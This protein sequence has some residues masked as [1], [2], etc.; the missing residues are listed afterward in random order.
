M[1]YQ[2][3]DYREIPDDLADRLRILGID[4]CTVT[5]GLA[6]DSISREYCILDNDHNIQ[7]YLRWSD[8]GFSKHAVCNDPLVVHLVDESVVLSEIDSKYREFD[9]FA[10]IVSKRDGLVK[11]L[12][13]YHKRN[14][15]DEVPE[16]SI[17]SHIEMLIDKLKN[18]RPLTENEELVIN[19]YYRTMRK[20][21]R[22]IDSDKIPKYVC[23]NNLFLS[24]VL[25]DNKGS[26]KF[27]DW[28]SSGLNDY[29][30]DYACLLARSSDSRAYL[31]IMGSNI[32]DEINEQY[33]DDYSN[34]RILMCMVLVDLVDF[35][36]ISIQ[37]SQ[38]KSDDHTQELLFKRYTT[39]VE[40]CY[41]SIDYFIQKYDRR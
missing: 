26:I 18:L 7:Y 33:C 37:P 8:R 6:I 3:V 41:T 13:S 9:G 23:H 27:R 11:S 31:T 22:L 17:S 4:K 38:F 12:R 25:I 34:I 20:V 30:W 24:K 14:Y 21:A 16:F 40:Q 15:D 32:T 28:S 29:A 10:E 2:P 5:T 1:K 19:Y 35:L 39:V 36:S